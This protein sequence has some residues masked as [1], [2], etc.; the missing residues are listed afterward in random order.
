MEKDELV[1]RKGDVTLRLVIIEK[2][3]RAFQQA[4]G[5]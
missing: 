5:R 4:L 2:G 1:E 3:E